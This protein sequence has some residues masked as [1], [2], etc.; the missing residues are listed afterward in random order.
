MAI[1]L[2]GCVV[3]SSIGCRAPILHHLQHTTGNLTAMVDANGNTTSFAYDG[4]NRLTRK[5]WPDDTFEEFTYDSAGNQTSHRRTDGQISTAVY[6]SMDRLRTVTYFDN[7]TEV[8]TY[9]LGGLRTAVTDLR[10]TTSYAYDPLQRLTSVTQPD[11]QAL[12]YSYDS[13]GNRA[14][15][16]TSAGTTQYTY[17]A[18]NRLL[19]V[20]DPSAGTFTNTYDALGN[21]TSLALPNGITT[22]YGY[23]PQNRLTNITQRLG[24]TILASYTYTLDPVGNRTRV[25]QFDGNANSS[26]LWTY[27]EAYRLTRETWQSS[28]GSP[29][30]TIDYTYDG[31][32]NRLSQTVNGTTTTYSYNVLDQLL[33]ATTGQEVTAYGYDGRGN[34]TSISDTSGTTMLTYNAAD[35]LIGVNR[36]GVTISATYDVSGRRV[37]QTVNGTGTNYVWDEASRYGDVVLEHDNSG[38]LIARYVLGG[39]ELLA[40]ERAGTVSYYLH[41]GQ[42]SVRA[43][44]NS[45]GTITDR[46][47]YTA[48]GEEQSRSGTTVNPYTYASQQQ[49]A[50]TGLHYLRARW[51][52]PSSGRFLSRD[53]FPLNYHDP[54][55][56]NRYGYAR[57]NPIR[58]IDPSGYSAITVQYRQ[59]F[60]PTTKVKVALAAAGLGAAC[61]YLHTASLVAAMNK[62][63]IK[64]IVMRSL[65]PQPCSIPVFIWPR[66]TEV[67][68]HIHDAQFLLGKPMLLHY[69]G[70]NDH[71]KKRRRL[72][73]TSP[74]CKPHLRQAGQECDEYPY[75]STWEGG[76]TNGAST[77]LVAG[78]DN[79][80]H[81]GMLGSFYEGG[82][83]NHW[84][85]SIQINGHP[86]AVVILP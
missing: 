68:Q 82:F 75:A 30:L 19:T 14:T 35:R 20:T 33:T 12:Q 60:I 76:K 59:A 22:S 70:I 74:N 17:D 39:A 25:D 38:T 86:F 62:D 84:N 29:L 43:L 2:L 81:G 51:Y 10:G 78:I 65:Q 3:T 73:R 18:L 23:D 4:L 72:T 8:Y 45:A 40:Q 16:T 36:P 26:I 77:R 13:A 56:H 44:A 46:Y 54:V 58:Y 32:R 37:Q 47:D 53:T 42:T 83:T 21:R 1:L 34:L 49:N 7:Q 41:D 66:Y 27:D 61:V 63:G 69:D 57:A 80:I 11:G 5:T 24:A 55:E 9:T 31:N 79:S 48:Y 15:M 52:D 67:G 71:D 64:L 85:R 50:E 6:D 28:G